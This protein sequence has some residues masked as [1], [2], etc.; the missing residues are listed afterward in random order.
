MEVK[1]SKTFSLFQNYE[2][3]GYLTYHFCSPGHGILRDGVHTVLGLHLPASL[4]V[5]AHHHQHHTEIS[6][7]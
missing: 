7:T 1:I 4:L 3:I 6:A 2:A 5:L